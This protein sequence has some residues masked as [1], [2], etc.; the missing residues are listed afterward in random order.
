LSISDSF[1]SLDVFKPIS[2]TVTISD[3]FTLSVFQIPPLSSN[4]SIAD[5]GSGVL[6]DYAVDY[7]A[8]VYAASTVITF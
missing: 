5:S 6:T 1:I 2:D 4:V 8:E 7:F 3:L